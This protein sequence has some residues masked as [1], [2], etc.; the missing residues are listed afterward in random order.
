MPAMAVLRGHVVLE[1][2]GL[3]GSSGSEA[4][5][6]S[7]WAIARS[8]ALRDATG[9]STREW[10]RESGDSD[11]VLGRSNGSESAQPSSRLQKSV[12]D[13]L[14]VKSRFGA[15]APAPSSDEESREANQ[16]L[17]G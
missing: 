9:R 15:Q 3:R 2:F 7:P 10:G 12:R 6:E 17:A 1:G 13:T 16:A 4:S 14:P 11:R 5:A 8:R